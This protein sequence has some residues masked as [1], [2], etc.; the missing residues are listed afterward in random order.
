MSAAKNDR[1]K[2]PMFQ[3]VLQ[4]QYLIFAN[5]TSM[6]SSTAYIIKLPCHEL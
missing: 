4:S 3:P 2:V 1:K 6:S 5:E